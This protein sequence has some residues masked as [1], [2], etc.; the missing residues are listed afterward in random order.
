MKRLIF[1]VALGLSSFAKGFIDLPQIKPKLGKKTLFC[2]SIEYTDDKNVPSA[3]KAKSV[4]NQVRDFYTRNSRGLLDIKV[5]GDKISVPFKNNRQWN[6]IKSFVKAKHPNFDMYALIVGPKLGTSHAG[7]GVAWLRGTLYRDAQHE[8]GHLLG[9]GHAGRYEM[10]KGKLVLNSYGD[11]ESVMGRFPS[12]TLTGA[13]YRWEGWL[14]KTEVAVYN[15]TMMGQVYE[16]KRITNQE[17]PMLSLV[18]VP[19]AYFHGEN[20]P[21]A[22]IEGKDN[23]P[24]RDAYVSFSNKCD[25]CLSLHLSQG[26]GSQKIQM[27]GKEYYDERFTGMHIKVVEG[28]KASMKFTI[29]FQPKPSTFVAEPEVPE[30]PEQQVVEGPDEVP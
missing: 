7:G 3:G 18:G 29:D 17:A 4:C 20:P 23:P 1:S 21:T 30:I 27:F 8:V 2:A 15:P 14:P 11:G 22:P 28:S 24:Q 10:E 6:D 5:Q 13:Q 12:S 25:A 19:H 9:L 26:G 16:I